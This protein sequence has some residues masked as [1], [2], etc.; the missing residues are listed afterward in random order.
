M[1]GGP[2]AAP[3][4]ACITQ[5]PGLTPNLSARELRQAKLRRIG[6]DDRDLVDVRAVRQ[7]RR[8]GVGP[9]HV[10]GGAGNDARGACDGRAGVRVLGVVK[11]L[12]NRYAAAG[13][14]IGK[15]RT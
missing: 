5:T 10:A 4:S 8:R 14:R 6:R 15:P 12:P 3:V 1:R 2:K 13:I 7:G 11:E 9:A